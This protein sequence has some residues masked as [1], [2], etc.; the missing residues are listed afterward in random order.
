MTLAPQIN[1]KS[2]KMAEA[3][4]ENSIERLTKPKP[5]FEPAP[6]RK[7]GKVSQSDFD[8]R[9]RERNQKQAEKRKARAKKIQ[10]EQLQ[11][12]RPPVILLIIS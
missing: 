10:A 6:E 3:L 11:E 5:T 4:D 9:Q 7:R 8:R 2:R 12:V 1:E